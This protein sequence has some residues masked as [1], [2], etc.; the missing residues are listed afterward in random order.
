[1][2]SG[3]TVNRGNVDTQDTVRTAA[4]STSIN[5]RRSRLR[6]PRNTSTD[7]IQQANDYA[8]ALHMSQGH[9]HGLGSQSDRESNESL[10]SILNDASS[11]RSTRSSKGRRIVR[12]LI[13]QANNTKSRSSLK[14]LMALQQVRHEATAHLPQI[15]QLRYGQN[16]E[17]R[18]KLG[19]GHERAQGDLL[20]QSKLDATIAKALQR[21]FEKEEKERVRQVKERERKERDKREAAERERLAYKRRIAEEELGEQTVRSISKACPKCR[22]HIQKS[23]GCE[24]VS[25]RTFRF[26]G[27]VTLLIVRQMTCSK[28]RHEFC[29]SC[30]A[31]YKN[32]RNQD[33]SAHNPGC[34][35]YR[36]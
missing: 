26:D 1:M 18:R 11:F 24:H 28:C 29:W 20:E 22:Y 31:D 35:F 3:A 34:T 17:S 6:P 8:I 15:P 10:G 7:D 33:N 30:L 27:I 32:I 14:A 25:L 2:D 21:Q 4:T 36:R 12:K 19:L 9:D 16:G 13:K 5:S 23:G